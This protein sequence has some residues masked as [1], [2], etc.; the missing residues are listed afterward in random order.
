MDL[1]FPEHTY[2]GSQ[3]S[4]QGRESQ[5]LA[6]QPVPLS[7]HA[8]VSLRDPSLKTHDVE[9]LRKMPDVSL[10]SPRVHTH[11]LTTHVCALTCENACIPHTTLKPNSAVLSQEPSA[12]L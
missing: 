8:P 10:G 6:G 3:S 5:D 7:G 9:R 11:M 12:S 4:L 2:T 1:G